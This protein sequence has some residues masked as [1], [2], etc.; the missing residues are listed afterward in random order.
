LATLDTQPNRDAQ[1]LGAWL[2]GV[3]ASSAAPFSARFQQADGARLILTATYGADQ[4]WPGGMVDVRLAWQADGLETWPPG[5]ISFVHLRRNGVNVTQQDGLPRYFVAEPLAVEGKWADWRQLQVPPPA[6]AGRWEVVVGLY[7]PATGE[8]LPVVDVGGQVIGDE[9]VI[10]TLQ[11]QPAPVP[12][13]SCALIAATCA[14]QSV[15]K[16]R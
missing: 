1:A 13:Q 3:T 7:E 5:V 15:D 2:H 14:S 12:D 4:L 9:A 16:V 8:R 10:G 6:E 11:W